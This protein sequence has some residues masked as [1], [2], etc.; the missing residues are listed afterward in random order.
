MKAG[1]NIS[2]FIY[3]SHSEM[4]LA[5]VNQNNRNAHSTDARSMN[6]F[7]KW[8]QACTA[9]LNEVCY[10]CECSTKGWLS[11]EH[12]RAVTRGTSHF[13]A[14]QCHGDPAAALWCKQVVTTNG[15]WWGGVEKDLGVFDKVDALKDCHLFML[16]PSIRSVFKLKH[17][18]GTELNKKLTE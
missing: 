6:S 11:L 3:M 1:L 9:A 16:Y 10:L 13:H 12:H 18:G 5:Q 17:D 8:L 2:C 4:R 15:K 7:P 14:N